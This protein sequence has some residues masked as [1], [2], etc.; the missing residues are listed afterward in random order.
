MSNIYNIGDVVK[1]N[2]DGPNMTVKLVPGYE[3]GADEA[4]EVY[5]CQWFAGKKLESGEFPEASLEL[6]KKK[7]A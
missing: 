6:V 5:R 2:S 7:P 1:L 3:M 4:R